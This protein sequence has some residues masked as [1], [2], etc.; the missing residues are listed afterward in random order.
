MVIQAL[1]G[2]VFSRFLHGRERSLDGK[3]G[4]AMLGHRAYIGGRWQELGQIQFDFMVS[5]GLRPEHVFLDIACGALRGGVHFIPYLEPEHYLGIEKERSLIRSGLS[6]ELSAAVRE[7]KRPELVV[8][9]SFEFDRFTKQPDYSLA[10]SLFTHLTAADIERCLAK[11]RA[12]VAPGHELYASFAD[13]AK[14]QNP[15]HSHALALFTH[16]TEDL[17]ASGERTG[18]ECE[19]IGTWG[20]GKSKMMKFLAR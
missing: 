6:K 10:Q 1:R 4:V 5:R 11:L 9:D 18:W 2:R 14:L 19:Y 13:R 8:S 7:E 20:H 15:E 3:V 17:E 12:F 16:Q